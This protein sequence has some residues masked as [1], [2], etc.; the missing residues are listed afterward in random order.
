MRIATNH[1]PPTP[2][3]SPKVEAA[4]RKL[5][6]FHDAGLWMHKMIGASAPYGQM[7]ATFP[8][9]SAAEK[10]RKARQFAD[11][12]KGYDHKE[13]NKLFT[14]CREHR[15]PLGTAAVSILLR[16]PKQKRDAVQQQL[17][18]NHWSNNQLVMEIQ[19]QRGIRNRGAG[20]RGRLPRDSA[21]VIVKLN[22]ICGQWDRLCQAIGVRADGENHL[23]NAAGIDLS[24][25]L[26]ERVCEVDVAM[27]RLRR[28]VLGRTQ[29]TKNL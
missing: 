20:R 8:D 6:Q 25:A 24:K 27:G 19:K 17:V 10:A 13:L 2:A 22:R 9:V 16:V 21:E 18:E 12:V 1:K 23:G 5:R 26:R 7:K 11:P 4:I 15:F 29:T 3:S 28:L 14:Q